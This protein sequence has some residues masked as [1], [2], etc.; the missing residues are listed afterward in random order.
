M[1]YTYRTTL[2]QPP[3]PPVPPVVEPPAPPVVEHPPV[4]E[5]QYYW[6]LSEEAKDLDS[7]LYVTML[8]IV[9]FAMAT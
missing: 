4:G 8:T 2:N 1:P 3:V 6:Q 5:V 9:T 7:A